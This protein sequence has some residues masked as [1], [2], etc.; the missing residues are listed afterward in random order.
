MTG[1]LNDGLQGHRIFSHDSRGG[2]LTGGGSVAGSYK[3][4]LGDE[5]GVLR[6]GLAE[7]LGRRDVI[8]VV[9]S[10]GDGGECARL[11]MREQPD[12][13]IFDT[14]LR[15]LCGTEVARRV[16][17]HSPRTRLLCLSARDEPRWIRA[18]FEAGA[19]A[20][21]L[22]RNAITVLMDAVDAVM[23]RRS[24]ISADIAHVLV[25]GLRTGTRPD[26][27]PAS[28]LSPREREVTRLY[29]E[30][31]ATRDIAGRLHLSMKTVATHRDHIMSK[32]GIRGIAQLTRYAMREG[33]IPMDA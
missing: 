5:H 15:G 3:V 33:L 7:M 13:L 6:D 31:M 25:D 20:Y 11:G 30:G 18:A 28:G 2:D 19:H 16:A 21:V 27:T 10:T 14:A 23:H 4:L 8:D 1:C 22:K 12:L 24:Y 29:A 17:R 26:G 9:G 32:L